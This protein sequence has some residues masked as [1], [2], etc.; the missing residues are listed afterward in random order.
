MGFRVEQDGEF[1]K[2]ELWRPMD[3]RGLYKGFVVGRGGRFLLGAML[4]EGDRLVARRRVS[5]ATLK[6]NGAWP[7]LDADTVLAFP[8]EEKPR[9]PPGW[10][11][12]AESVRLA[13]D[14]L[15][16]AAANLSGGLIHRTKG[17]FR[18]AYP[19][20]TSFPFPMTLLFCFAEIMQLGGRM[21]AVFRFDEEGRPV[22]PNREEKLGDTR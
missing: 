13:D 9:L 5:V 12:L 8:F 19:F 17:G 15:S 11:P 4:P 21:R 2:I 6:G 16:K 14:V 22:F 1:A 20:G 3:S 7:V 10:Q 18:L